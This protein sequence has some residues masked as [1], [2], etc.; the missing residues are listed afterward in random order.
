MPLRVISGHDEIR[1][2][3]LLRIDTLANA[4]VGAVDIGLEIRC[5]RI[6]ASGIHVLGCVFGAIQLHNKFFRTNC[7][8][9]NS[10]HSGIDSRPGHSRRGQH[11][12]KSMT[13]PKKPGWAFWTTAVLAGLVLYVAGF[14]PTC[15]LSSR[16]LL[17]SGFMRQIYTPIWSLADKHRGPLV[18]A[19]RWYACVGASEIEWLPVTDLGSHAMPIEII[20]E[21]SAEDEQ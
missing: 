6:P 15:W 1:G 5:R 17:P 14:G 8:S 16:G 18:S 9:D 11:E 2:G 7:R 10:R 12:T 4:F 3:G 21:P 20:P 13:D 19:V